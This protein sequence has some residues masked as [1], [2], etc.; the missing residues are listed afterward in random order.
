MKHSELEKDAAYIL[1]TF[2][3]LDY[4]IPS[5][6]QILKIIFSKLM[7]VYL[8]QIFF[9]VADVLL[10]SKFGKYHYFDTL[11]LAMGSNVFLV[12]FF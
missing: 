2:K 11:V 12:L 10:K 9:I 6:G 1:E 3:K 4:E 5:N 7:V 8:L